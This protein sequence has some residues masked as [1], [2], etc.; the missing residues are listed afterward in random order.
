MSLLATQDVARKCGPT[1][2]KRHQAFKTQRPLKVVIFPK[3][4]EISSEFMKS[5]SYAAHFWSVA[6]T[7]DT[8]LADTQ[9]HLLWNVPGL[10]EH[11]ISAHH[12]DAPLLDSATRVS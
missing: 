1:G 2:Q 3:I 12:I 5:H 11:D 7:P 8:S 6:S 4:L 9:N 10:A